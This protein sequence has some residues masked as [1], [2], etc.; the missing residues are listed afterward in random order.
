MTFS[1]ETQSS[2]YNT[3]VGDSRSLDHEETILGHLL[4][5]K[6][7]SLKDSLYY[8]TTYAKQETKSWDSTESVSSAGFWVGM[9]AGGAAFM[10]VGAGPIGMVLG[11]VVAAIGSGGSWFLK[12]T[13]ERVGALRRTEFELHRNHPWIRDR[14]WQL[15]QTGATSAEIVAIYDRMLFHMFAN[16]IPSDGNTIAGSM[17]IQSPTFAD[18]PAKSPSETQAQSGIQNS[19]ADNAPRTE[20]QALAPTELQP[21]A[22]APPSMSMVNGVES[23]APRDIA[24]DLGNNPQSALIFGTPGAGKGMTISNAIRTLRAKLPAVTVMMV[25]PKGDKKERGYWESQVDIFENR[26]LLKSSPR[27]SAEWMLRCVE[28]FSQ[29]DGPKLLVWDELFA[30]ITVLKGQNIPKGEDAFPCLTEFQQFISLNLSLGP[31]SGTWVWGMSQSANLS[32]LGLTSG[33]LSTTRIIALISPDNV[34]AVEGYL[35]TKAIT[36]PKG[37]METLDRMMAD[38]PVGRACYDG[39]TKRWYPTA[40]LENHSGFDRDSADWNNLGKSAP[41]TRSPSPSIEERKAEIER[42]KANI[43]RLQESND[44]LIDERISSGI[45]YEMHDSFDSPHERL[46]R[47][48][49]APDAIEVD[50]ETTA[51][52]DKP[53]GLD[54]FPLVL[55]IWEYLDGKDARSLK[56]IRDAMRKTGRISEDH[57]R[58]RL[59]A[60]EGYNEALKA[61]I[62]FGVGRGFLKEVSEDTYEAIKAH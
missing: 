23:I 34:G 50:V 3:S 54:D 5:E 42:M 52:D 12:D 44:E 16:G 25:D 10:A 29:I 2:R 39:K 9:V 11:G 20:S 58:A 32:D 1:I 60:I 36:A 53:E 45:D 43:A 21:I 26:S 56:Q 61:V 14:L 30:S 17:G 13:A 47:A 18:L 7:Y 40:R 27:S 38:S 48:W 55:T 46:E 41:E 15:S 22:A 49:V 35:A 62:Q 24:T 31:S 59:P 57:L 6:Q 51:I 4:T 37:G 19:G 8:L 33:G 28:K